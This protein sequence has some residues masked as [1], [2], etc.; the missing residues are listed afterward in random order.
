MHKNARAHALAAILDEENELQAL[1]ELIHKQ[2][3]NGI[4]LFKK[5]IQRLSSE[6][7]EETV[8]IYAQSIR[9]A[10]RQTGR[11]VYELAAGDM[12]ALAALPGGKASMQA[13]LEEFR[14][15]YRNRKA[16]LEIFNRV[17]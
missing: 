6:L 3:H 10:M 11:S 14:V 4:T 16:M 1:F 2:G 9:L 17:F 12:K 13:L 5:Y 7:P 15:E 8:K